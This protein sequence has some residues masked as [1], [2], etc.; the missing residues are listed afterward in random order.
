M[1]LLALAAAQK[2]V[3]STSTSK[4]KTASQ[5]DSWPVVQQDAKNFNSMGIAC[6]SARHNRHPW[7][8]CA[9]HSS[10]WYNTWERDLWQSE[11]R[12][13]DRVNCGLGYS[14]PKWPDKNSLPS[15]WLASTNVPA[16]HFWQLGLPVHL[17]FQIGHPQTYQLFTL[18]IGSSSSFR[19][20][21]IQ[22]MY[23]TNECYFNSCRSKS[24]KRL[25]LHSDKERKFNV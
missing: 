11:A 21:E 16:V 12:K 14:H 22:D 8:S 20:P 10:A 23:C 17:N 5:R 19:F 13:N 25:H 2:Q 6:C 7:V 9:N 3:V 24:K 1:N 15:F 4:S 18:A